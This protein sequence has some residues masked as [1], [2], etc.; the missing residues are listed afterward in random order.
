MQLLQSDTPWTQFDDRGPAEPARA[1]GTVADDELREPGLRLALAPAD[2]AGVI[3]YA[4]RS[5]SIKQKLTLES[6]V[7]LGMDP[8]RVACL[9]AET[10]PIDPF[11]VRV[12]LCARKT[13]APATPDAER[14][15]VNLTVCESGSC[16]TVSVPSQDGTP[17]GVGELL[18][19]DVVPTAKGACVTARSA[20]TADAALSPEYAPVGETRCFA[21]QFAQLGLSRPPVDGAASP[22][23][24][25]ATMIN[26]IP[27]RAA[28]FEA[29]LVEPSD[30][31]PPTADATKL[32]DL[33]WP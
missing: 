21:Q 11:V 20:R 23:L 28:H 8:T 32:T 30:G 33:S 15:V 16:D 5:G 14:L 18:S 31:Q 7:S 24:F 1:F 29:V 12:T 13:I 19:L 4:Y 27:V 26:G 25:F 9:V 22:V 2:G 10:D 3:A 6:V 17:G